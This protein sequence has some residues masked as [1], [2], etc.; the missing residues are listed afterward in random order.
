MQYI[1][2]SERQ[3]EGAGLVRDYRKAERAVERVSEAGEDSSV[4]EVGSS[5][6]SAKWNKLF[7]L[8]SSVF[9]FYLALHE[10]FTTPF[11]A[12]CSQQD[13]VPCLLELN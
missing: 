1:A 3:R 6:R 13:G 9:F 5:L 12:N 7:F 8:S 11:P 10:I 4:G 2:C